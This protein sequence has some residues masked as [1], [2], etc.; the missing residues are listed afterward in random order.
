MF[1]LSIINIKGRLKGLAQKMVKQRLFKE[2]ESLS[3]MAVNNSSLFVVADL[4]KKGYSFAYG[5]PITD[6]RCQR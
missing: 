1:K 6:R 3:N 2:E 5:L 4:E